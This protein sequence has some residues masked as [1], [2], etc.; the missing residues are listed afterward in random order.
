MIASLLSNGTNA[1][2]IIRALEE[3]G[4]AR[5]LAEPNLISLSGDT[6]S[7]LAGGEFPFPSDAGDN[8]ISIEFKKFGIALAFTPTVLENGLINLKIVPEVSDIDPTNSVRIN[9]VQVPGLVVRRAD[10][11]VELRNGQS[12]AIAG[13]L[14]H[15]SSRNKAQLPWIGQVP[16]LGALFRSAEY[17]KNETDL[18]I[19]VTPRLVKP[20]IPGENLQTPLGNQLSSNDRDFFLMGRSEIPK[21]G[22]DRFT[23]RRGAD[24]RYGH[25]I[26]IEEDAAPGSYK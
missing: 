20:K 4:V 5:R 16:V 7:F 26:Q 12:F 18:V 1:D 25:I 17:K 3:R 19:I 14:Q 21:K 15:S 2:A 22:Y 8:K 10:T 24:P 9:D 6:A 23:L 13:L 11:T